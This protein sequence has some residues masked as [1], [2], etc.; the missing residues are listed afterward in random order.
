MSP[1]GGRPPREPTADLGDQP[2][3][4]GQ[5][6]EL[7][8]LKHPACGVAP[9]DQGLD[10]RRAHLAEGDRRL[11]G[12]E[13]LVVVQSVA[14]IHFELHARLDRVLHAGLEGG[15]TVLAV[16]LGPVHG[17]VRIAQQF[18]GRANIS[19]RHADARIDPKDVPFP[20]SSL[21]GGLSASRSRSAIR[22]GPASS[23]TPSEITTNSS[24]PSRPSASP[25]RTT[26]SSLCATA[27]RSSSPAR[28]TERVVDRL[29]VVEIDEQRRDG[30]IGTTCACEHL[31]D[32]IDDQGSVRKPGQ[33]IMGGEKRQ[34]LFAV[35]EL[36]VGSPALR[37][38]A[39]RHAQEA[40]VEAH[41]KDAPRLRER[42]RRGAQLSCDLTEHL[43]GHIAPPQAAPGHQVERGG[44]LRGELAEDLP[45]FPPGLRATSRPS[46][47]IRRATAIVELVQIRSKHS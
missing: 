34:L 46:P 36:L 5:G 24:P 21:K 15:V 38:K 39:L 18:L 45:C 47:A 37:L 8:G 19:H 22:S 6:D 14:Q 44:A 33:G 9:A 43:R 29:E 28:V 41:L 35:G 26:P 32:A 25:P 20:T 10:A 4:L 3:L 30:R 27:L 23:E 11:V 12:E 42:L 13:E 40:E 17:D 2:A 1:P 16:P 31:L 7:V